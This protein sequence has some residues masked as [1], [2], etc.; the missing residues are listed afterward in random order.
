MNRKMFRS[1]IWILILQ[2]IIGPAMLLAQTDAAPKTNSALETMLNYDYKTY[3]GKVLVQQIRED[4]AA[5]RPIDMNKVSKELTGKPYLT[6]VAIGGGSEVAANVLQYGMTG[7]CPPYGMIAGAIIASTMQAFGGAVGYESS[8]AMKSGKTQTSKQILG[9]ALSSIDMP[10]FIGQTTGG[11]IGSMVG[12]ALIPIPIV[13]MMIGSIV[14]SLV[15]SAAVNLL[16]KI[17]AFASAFDA[18][19]KKW[20]KIGKS[21]MENEEPEPATD[22]PQVTV[23]ATADTTSQST[24]T[25]PETNPGSLMHV[26]PTAADSLASENGQ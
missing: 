26:A 5:G 22:S 16:R 14:G 12:Q 1:L 18:M 21:M 20:E 24:T 23:T 25:Q 9:K 4:L 15:G 7:V 19:Q 2:L 3:A 13:G 17:P 6:Q 11:V 8:E 10:E